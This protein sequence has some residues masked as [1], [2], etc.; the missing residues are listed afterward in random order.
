[1]MLSEIVNKLM[2]VADSTIFAGRCICITLF[3]AAIIFM[4][5]SYLEELLETYIFHVFSIGY[6][7]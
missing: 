1:M 4:K 5:N 3:S 7:D 6:F 2:L